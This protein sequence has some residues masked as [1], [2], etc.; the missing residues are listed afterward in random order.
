M[1]LKIIARIPEDDDLQYGTS[2]NPFCRRPFL[3]ALPSNAWSKTR[4]IHL[5]NP[6]SAGGRRDSLLDTA[7]VRTLIQRIVEH[8]FAVSAPDL[9]DLFEH[10]LLYDSLFRPIM[11]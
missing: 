9:D 8:R 2:F 6:A 11:K 7:A 5:E 1:S 3:V 10:C 4:L